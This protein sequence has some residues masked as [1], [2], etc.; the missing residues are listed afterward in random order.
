MKRQLTTVFI[1]MYKNDNTVI[2]EGSR[3]GN[4][5]K[6]PNKGGIRIITNTTDIPTS[7]AVIHTYSAVHVC[8]MCVDDG[9]CVLAVLS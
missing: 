6:Y 2:A 3:Y 7:H 4:A 8:M 1:L 5:K 9:M